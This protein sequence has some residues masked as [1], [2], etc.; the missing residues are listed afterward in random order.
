[1]DLQPMKIW[2]DDQAD[3]S[4]AVL[5][6]GTDLLRSMTETNSPE[7]QVAQLFETLRMPVYLYLLAVFGNPAEAED[8]TQDAFLLL[9]KALNQG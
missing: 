6:A 9:Y 8:L 7:Q 1:M 3:S 2:V 5:S 4:S